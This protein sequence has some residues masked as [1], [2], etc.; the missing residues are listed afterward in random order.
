ME[1]ALLDLLMLKWSDL[2]LFPFRFL[3]LDFHW[4]S[5]ICWTVVSQPEKS[6]LKKFS[7]AES[8]AG[9]FFSQVCL[10]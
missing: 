2:I 1:K 8:S 10:E 9:L 4:G 7:C 3:E 5:L 6:G